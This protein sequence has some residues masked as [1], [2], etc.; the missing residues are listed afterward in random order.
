M[1]AFP[2]FSL[3]ASAV[4]LFGAADV[5]PIPFEEETERPAVAETGRLL[6]LKD[7]AADNRGNTPPGALA[8]LVA[9]PGVVY[10]WAPSPDRSR[11]TGGAD[12]VDA[13]LS[14]DETLLVVLEKVGGK[15]GPNATRVICCNLRNGKIVRGFTIPERKL[16]GAAPVPGSTLFVAPQAAQEAFEQPDRLVSVDLRSGR[17]REESQP[18]ERPVRSFAVTAGSTYVTLEGGDSVLAIPHEAFTETPKQMKT[19]VPEPR[20]AASPDGSL[21]IVYGK[22]RCEIYSTGTEPPELLSSRELPPDFNPEWALLPGNSADLLILAENSGQALLFSGEISRP[23]T[24][25][26]AGTGCVR[27]A[28]RLLFLAQDPKEAIGVYHLPTEVV[29]SITVSPGE[30]RP[31][32]RGR[33]FRL[34]VLTTSGEPELLLIDSH[35][36]IAWLTVKP[37]RWQ[38][39]LLFA[40]PK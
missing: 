18:F 7:P 35:A 28:D 11:I 21:L 30:L 38:K 17:L 23:L 3:L 29:P 16:A 1:R 8:S 10:D 27:M 6:E 9:R 33:N 32:S 5:P 31:F 15:E 13:F 22:G 2:T 14:S 26:F 37:R 40:A 4:L 25:K 34:F 24:D 19:L 20:V 39:E 12:L 36:N